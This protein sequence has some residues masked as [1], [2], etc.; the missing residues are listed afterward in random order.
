MLNFSIDSVL[1][2]IKHLVGISSTHSFKAVTCRLPE[3][4]LCLA[5]LQEGG[6]LD[7]QYR[8]RGQRV[9]V[10]PWPGRRRAALLSGAGLCRPA[11]RGPRLT[12]Q[13]S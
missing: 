10:T 3:E 13:V 2:N 11:G 5:E 12:C 9:T 6:G 7:R 4:V 1:K 8:S